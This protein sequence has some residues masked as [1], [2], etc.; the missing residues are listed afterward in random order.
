MLSF[1]GALLTTILQYETGINFERYL[2]IVVICLANILYMAYR[3]H[4]ENSYINS[5]AEK[6]E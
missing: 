4:T 5:L 6:I 3:I 2:F 1:I